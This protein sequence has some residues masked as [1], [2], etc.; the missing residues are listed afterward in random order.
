MYWSTYRYQLEAFVDLLRGREP[1]W[2]IDNGDSVLQMKTI[3]EIYRESG[4]PTNLLALETEDR[5][6]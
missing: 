2:W 5:V 4:M 6:V 1:V 3:D